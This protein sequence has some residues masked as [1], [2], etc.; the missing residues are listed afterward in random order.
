MDLVEALLPGLK[1]FLLND[2]DRETLSVVA[3]AK[4]RALLERLE[5]L[6]FGPC[7]PVPDNPVDAVP[8]AL[9]EAQNHHHSPISKRYSLPPSI[10]G[11]PDTSDGTPTSSSVHHPHFERSSP[12]QWSLEEVPDAFLDCSSSPEYETPADF[13]HLVAA[14]AAATNASATM[15]QTP[16]ERGSAITKL[17]PSAPVS[18]RRCTLQQQQQQSLV[19]PPSRTHPTWHHQ[20]H[21]SAPTHRYSL[22][23]RARFSLSPDAKTTSSDFSVTTSNGIASNQRDTIPPTHSDQLVYPETGTLSLPKKSATACSSSRNF[24]PPT[25]TVTLSG[26]LYHRYKPNKWTR[27]GLCMLTTSARF[28]G[29]K[30]SPTGS[31]GANGASTTQFSSAP[32]SVSVFL[33]SASSAVY[34][35][36]DSGMDH[37][38]KITHPAPQLATVLAA[39]TEEEALI[40]IQ[41]INQ[42]AQGNTPVAVHPST[43]DG[44]PFVSP[45]TVVPQP[46]DIVAKRSSG[47]RLTAVRRKDGRPQS[48]LV[49]ST[50]NVPV[51]SLLAQATLAVGNRRSEY[52]DTQE[53]SGFSGPLSSSSSAADATS[54]EGPLISFVPT[55][56]ALHVGEPAHQRPTSY[57]DFSSPRNSITYDFLQTRA[58]N[59]LSSVRRKV[60]E[61]LHSRRRF[62]KSMFDLSSSSRDLTTVATAAAAAAG[63]FNEESFATPPPPPAACVTSE[64]HILVGFGWGQLDSGASLLSCPA[65]SSGSVFPASFSSLTSP[66]IRSRRSLVS[67]RSPPSATEFEPARTIDAVGERC[68]PES[69]TPNSSTLATAYSLLT[70]VQAVVSSE[71]F[72]SIPGRLPWTKHWCVLRA[73]VLEIYLSNS[74]PAVEPGRVT[75]PSPVFSLPLKPKLV[76]LSLAGDKRHRSAIKL[77]APSLCRSALFFDALDKV[78]MGTWIRGIL[79]ALGHIDQPSTQRRPSDV[80]VTTISTPPV[81]H[82]RQLPV[83]CP[84]DPVLKPNR[85][86]DVSF[87][88]GG[89]RYSLPDPPTVAGGRSEEPFTTP[90][91][92]HFRRSDI[93]PIVS[94]DES[95]TPEPADDEGPLYDE[96]ATPLPASTCSPHEP[97]HRWSLPLPTTRTAA[98]E[99]SRQALS[100][101][102]SQPSQSRSGERVLLHLDLNAQPL[103]PLISAHPSRAPSTMRS[104]YSNVYEPAGEEST[105]GC[106]S[107]MAASDYDTVGMDSTASTTT[108]S[109]RTAHLRR[110]LSLDQMQLPVK[111]TADSNSPHRRPRSLPPCRRNAPA[112]L[113]KKTLLSLQAKED[114]SEADS[115]GYCKPNRRQIIDSFLH[116]S[117]E[118]ALTAAVARSFSCMSGSSTRQL[119]SGHSEVTASTLPPRLPPSSLPLRDLLQSIGLDVEMPP[120]PPPTTALAPSPARTASP[121]S[122]SSSPSS[123]SISASCESTNSI[124]GEGTNQETTSDAAAV[125]AAATAAAVAGP[126]PLRASDVASRS[127]EP[128]KRLHDALRHLDAV[129]LHPDL[130]SAFIADC[131][132]VVSNDCDKSPIEAPVATSPQSMT[133]LTKRNRRRHR[134][135][136]RN[137][138]RNRKT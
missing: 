56:P 103:P 99:P 89:H 104:I 38:I 14:A 84:Y 111:S 123:S 41:Q 94:N 128:V 113:A 58:S 137:R 64:G 12:A 81:L 33:C 5:V 54:A 75:S 7:P 135:A 101:S 119:P 26:S 122:S 2:L 61:S 109:D 17:L 76:E 102:A 44:S 77:S 114:T 92:G 57:A 69:P 93:T 9:P 67:L 16:V 71:A 24:F 29:F 132:I 95:D 98:A 11:C 45:S 1:S 120:T 97:T 107:T 131:E 83:S 35:G 108:A 115:A 59:L 87:E 72:I 105:A 40:W 70:S 73:S 4:R 80:T 39:D 86:S 90:L 32:P 23:E 53:D 124:S 85:F 65:T 136:R 52:F 110:T 49:S 130:G 27:L 138:N 117:S 20:Q 78:S 74:C 91:P 21:K 30:K 15:P 10:S 37:V 55:D 19:T 36:R 100:P 22:A 68:A 129:L 112:H 88:R 47:S 133:N 82:L 34:A 116:H 106:K 13:A 118:S 31:G 79:C 8:T 127:V 50:S 48:L 121:S 63:E 125:A 3:E 134:S 96:V 25:D 62:R 60:T 18:Q 42:Y 46:S 66:R 51:S 28:L 43:L 6:A 126:S